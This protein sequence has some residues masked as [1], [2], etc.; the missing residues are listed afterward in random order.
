MWLD[1]QAVLYALKARES[2]PA[3][4]ITDK[5]LAQI[6]FNANVARNEAY[7]LDIAWVKG[8]T[9]NEGNE[10]A[11][12]EA[13]EAAAGCTSRR[14]ALLAFLTEAALPLSI[15]AHRQAFDGELGAR[16]C[17]EWETST[18]FARINMINPL[19]PS[20]QFWKLA[21]KLNRQQTSTLVQLRMGHIPLQKHLLQI[22][23][24]DNPTCQ[25]CSQGEESVHHFLFEC[26]A[27]QHERWR[28]STKLGRVA[29][30]ANS[31]MNTPKGITE[32]MKYVGRTGRFKDKD[33]FGELS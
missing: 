5:I 14:C 2:G 11:D 28:M 19:M 26:A 7:W 12:K 1:N 32:F 25:H 9:R 10:R 24:V 8:H 18:M 22:A 3:Q 6:A 27:W 33:V 15:A 23:R 20:K 13:K 31:V 30:E 29:K 17:H 21:G 16:W 4:R